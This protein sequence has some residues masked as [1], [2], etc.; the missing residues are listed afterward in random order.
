VARIYEPI[1]ALIRKRTRWEATELAGTEV[2]EEVHE[3]WGWKK[4]R[5]VVLI[6]HLK[7]R[8]P[9]A[10]GKL[11]IDCPEYSFQVLATNLPLGVSGLEV[12]RRYNGRA[13]SENIIRELDECFAL[14]QISLQKFYATEAALSLAVLSYNLCVLFQ[15]HLGWMDKVTAGTLRF[16]VFTTGG[17]ISR[18]GGYMTIRLAVRE[19][20]HRDWWA[21]VLEKLTC[22]LPNCVAVETFQPNWFAGAAFS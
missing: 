1:H 14:P 12:W 22:P 19:R 16:L 4:P 10:G 8:R 7:S 6:R 3:G 2:A 15:R 9:D 13:G 20:R 21:R 11:L 17:V 18:S 5:R